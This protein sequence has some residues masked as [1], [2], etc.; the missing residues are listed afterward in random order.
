M[1]KKLKKTRNKM[2]F[3]FLSEVI[4][5]IALIIV[6]LFAKSITVIKNYSLHILCVYLLVVMVVNI[7]FATNFNRT[8]E[9]F[10]IRSDINIASIFGS[11]VSSIFEFGNLALFVYNEDDEIIWTN[12]TTLFKRAE[13]IGKS[14][15]SFL[16]DLDKYSGDNKE[17]IVTVINGKKFLVSLNK[18]LKVV[19]LKNITKE[20]M[21]KQ[22]IEEN[23]LF[24]GHIIIDNYQDI[25]TSYK[26]ADFL[27]YLTRVKDTIIKW[28][29]DNHLFVRSYGNDS[30]LILGEEKHYL[31]IK[32]HK[33]DL[34]NEIRKL[35]KEEDNPLTI[36]IGIGKGRASILRISELSYMALNMALSRGG[37]QVVV[38]TF[39]YPLEYFGAKNEIKQSRSHVRGRVLATSICNLIKEAKDVYIMGHKDADFDAIGACLG[40]YAICESLNTKALIVYE[41]G[42]TD[43]QAKR[44]FRNLPSQE[45]NKMI[46][47]PTR[48]LALAH[49]NSLVIVVDTHRPQ[50]T[51]QPLLLEKCKDVCVIDHHRRSDVFINN[52]I[53]IYHEPQS[54][55]TCE[56]ITELLYYQ[57]N[58]VNLSADIAN[59]M[60]A[61]ICLDTRFYKSNTSSKTFEM[62][63][64]LKMNNASVD[65]VNDFFK[66]EYEEKMLLNSIVGSCVSPYTG[67]II[68]KS[69]E[70]DIITKTALAKAAEEILNTKSIFAVFVVGRTSEK[71]VSISARSLTNFNVQIIM[72]A[73]NG[74]GHFTS[75]AT[76]INTNESI[77]KII[78]QLEETLTIYIRDGKV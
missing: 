47:S 40:V 59:F 26:E 15:Y 10:L 46:V 57:T 2:I 74:G 76:Q 72:E 60:L 55:S 14:I 63:M 35:M 71:Q 38:N 5:G 34:L 8:V 24:M 28:T 17:E 25:F 19:Y 49:E 56:L 66:E 52:P 29:K 9:K 45:I 75:A 78:E 21:E 70:K 67:I 51:M 4:L 13:V 16:P 37:D 27:T 22:Y 32:E 42:L 6:Y 62:S 33:F 7:I 69:S 53:F 50:S 18:G 36:S 11:E 20:D 43:Y 77:D 1:F 44:A 65:V 58:K 39:G 23:S 73:M 68:A 31:K 30:F 48:A 12:Q 41:D 54:S 3:L 61:G 64:V